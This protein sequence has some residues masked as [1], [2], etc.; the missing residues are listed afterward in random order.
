MLPLLRAAG[1]SHGL[2]GS[3]FSSVLSGMYPR[4]RVTRGGSSDWVKGDDGDR[5]PREQFNRLLGNNTNN[6]AEEDSLETAWQ[7]LCL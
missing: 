6:K 7:A 1:W 5:T 2:A 4:E 3:W